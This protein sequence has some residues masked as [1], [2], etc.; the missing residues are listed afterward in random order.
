MP[1]SGVPKDYLDFIDIL[2]KHDVD[3]LI[4]GAYAVA[5]HGCPRNTEDFDVL[6]RSV[7]E[8]AAKLEAALREFGFESIKVTEADLR[9]EQII[10]LGVKPV[11]IDVITA[12]TGVTAE[13]L[14][15]DRIKGKFEGRDV[16]YISRE[17]LIGN[18]S[19]TG[20]LKD[21]AD[22]EK[23]QQQEKLRKR[24]KKRRRGSAR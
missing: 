19:A 16:F 9:G 23:L 3:Y 24:T 4:V 20:R 11:R 10:Q 21:K 17:N 2:G 6:A 7:P 1:E 22:V 8:N 18:K 5:Y 13:K 12:V 14:W 15:K